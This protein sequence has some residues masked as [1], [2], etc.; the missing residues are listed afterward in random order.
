MTEF[1]LKLE[2]PAGKLAAVQAAVAAEPTTRVHLRALYI[3]TPDRVLA[4]H[5]IALRLRQENGRWVQTCKAPGSGP[6]ERFE[7]N[8]TIDASSDDA[9]P[10]DV[11]RH[12]GTPLGDRLRAALGAAKDPRWDVVFETDVQRVLREVRQG[13]STLELALDEGRIL[14]GGREHAVREVEVELKEGRPQDAVRF[15]R[16]WAARHGLWLS[17]ISKAQR[18]RLLAEGRTAGEAV[19][20]Q[21][22]RY[23]RKAS[24]G[25]VVRA[26]LASCLAHVIG[27][28]SEIAAGSED[29]EHVHQLRVGIRRLR[30]ALRELQS[31]APVDAGCEPALVAAFRALGEQRDQAQVLRSFA[32]RIE[33][34]GG[35]RPQALA[36][37]VA[38]SAPGEVVRAPEFQDA[39]LELLGQ[40]LDIADE[41]RSP[42]KPL[43]RGLQRLRRQVVRDGRQFAALEPALQ[44]RVRKRLKRLRYLADFAEP[45]FPAHGQH[46]FIEALKPVQDALGANND[47]LV[48]LQVYRDMAQNDA[49]ALFGVG[50]LTAQLEPQVRACEKALRR[51]AKADPFWD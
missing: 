34:A 20:A 38:P 12:D 14:A 1:E 18:G 44:H 32:P 11:A 3:D 42:R 39:M 25:E 37:P 43:R 26:V 6:V 15:A 48:A 17:I 36:Q 5:G 51:L 27:N 23:P 40:Q 10:P 22:V 13:A 21:P 46:A 16:H 24:S 35:P 47:L 19:H 4:R 49:P 41:C 8:A 2:I 28:A 50:W 33:A 30:T 45:L 9:P 29:E 7:H 31:L